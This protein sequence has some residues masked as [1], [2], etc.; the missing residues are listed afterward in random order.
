M[1][2]RAVGASFTRRNKDSQALSRQINCWASPFF[3]VSGRR[4]GASVW[5][6]AE[7]PMTEPQSESRISETAEIEVVDEA[8]DRR[9]ANIVLGVGLLLLIGVGWWLA[10]ALFEA[11]Q[12][13]NCISSGRRNCTPIETPSRR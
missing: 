5:L 10:N 9:L 8:A 1:R 3:C 4:F 13:D 12:A 11:R 2:A 7:M 6:L